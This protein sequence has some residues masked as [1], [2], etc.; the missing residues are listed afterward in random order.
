MG[1]GLYTLSIL[2][3]ASAQADDCG[4]YGLSY[5]GFLDTGACFDISGYARVELVVND[6]DNA[7]ETPGRAEPNARLRTD[8]KV[9]RETEIGTLGAF[10]RLQADYDPGIFGDLIAGPVGG[11]FAVGLDAFEIDLDTQKTA[12]RLGEIENAGAAFISDG[13]TERGAESLDARSGL[14]ASYQYAFPAA[15][16]RVSLSDPRESTQANPVSPNFGLG[17]SRG[18]GPVSLGFGA[19]FVN[20][21]NVIAEAPRALAVRRGDRLRIA[22]NAT[23]GFGVGL[24]VQYERDRLKT[25]AGAAYANNAAN[26]VIFSFSDGFDAVTFYAGFSKQLLD[27]LTLN[28]DISYVTAVERGLRNLNGV[29]AAF[30]VTWRPLEDWRLLGEIGFDSV[31]DF[32]AGNGFFFKIEN[33]AN[34]DFLLQVR[35]DF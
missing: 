17:I 28:G 1:I 23:Y 11:D 25:F 18:F 31:D 9:L 8:I 32:G 27:R 12:I 15:T 34:I 22:R 16:V 2:C 35:R 5:K 13:F 21:D 7:S 33:R 10:V 24:D 6:P 4:R 29:E 3:A 30:N 26:D 19:A 14:G 20:V